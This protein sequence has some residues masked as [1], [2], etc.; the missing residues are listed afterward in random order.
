M[1]FEPAKPTKLN[2][3]NY[4][5]LYHKERERNEILKKKNNYCLAKMNILTNY[6]NGGER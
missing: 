5:K 3:K 1:S 2:I 6:K 4:K